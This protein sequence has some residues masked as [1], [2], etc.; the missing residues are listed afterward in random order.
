MVGREHSTFH[1]NF[2]RWRIILKG[3]RSS[4]IL[5]SNTLWLKWCASNMEFTSPCFKHIIALGVV[6]SSTKKAQLLNLCCNDPIFCI[7][8]LVALLYFSLQSF[9]FTIIIVKK[10]TQPFHKILGLLA[11]IDAKILSRKDW[12][13]NENKFSV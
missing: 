2:E 8:I 9:L 1:I 7:I 5:C 12:W 13:Y 6:Y 10:Q 11:Q 4:I 3:N